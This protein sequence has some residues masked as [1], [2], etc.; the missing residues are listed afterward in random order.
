MFGESLWGPSVVPSPK[1]HIIVDIKI[2]KGEDCDCD[3]TGPDSQLAITDV[4][5]ITVTF[6]MTLSFPKAEL[7]GLHTT[8]SGT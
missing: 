2:V 8:S 5:Q 7:F 6:W 1:I 4:L 3:Q